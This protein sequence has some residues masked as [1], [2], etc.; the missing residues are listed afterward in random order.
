MAQDQ[1]T[2]LE[3][4]GTLIGVAG[5][6]AGLTAY[7]VTLQNG[8]GNAVDDIEKLRSSLASLEAKYAGVTPDTT[9]A[10][11]ITALERKLTELQATAGRHG[12]S[13]T[14]TPSID[15]QSGATAAEVKT[16]ASSQVPADS[17]AT[18]GQFAKSDWRGSVSC[19]NVQYSV[20]YEIAE[21]MDGTASGSFSWSGSN[22]G[23]AKAT[24][25]E[26]PARSDGKGLLLVTDGS[27]AYDYRLVYDGERLSGTTTKDNCSIILR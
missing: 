2:L 7:C 6:V 5:A 22:T 26:D 12:T 17:L 15:P 23:S 25:S 1:K 18:G 16:V 11:R 9:S 24:L 8:L 27:S 19:R 10:E 4:I 13:A 3:H 14:A 20:R 21:V